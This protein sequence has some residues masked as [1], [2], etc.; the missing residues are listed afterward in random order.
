M[1]KLLMTL[2]A[3]ISSAGFLA[4]QARSQGPPQPQIDVLHYEIDAE[5]TPENGFLKGETKVRFMVPQDVLTIPF[6][7]N[8]RLSVTEIVD[9]EGTSYSTSFDGVESQRIAVRGEGPFRGGSEKTLIFRFE[10]ALE[11]QEYAFLDV[12]RSEKAV[13]FQD[14]ALLLTEGRW[15]PFY[16]L[17]LDAATADLKIKVPLGF[18]VVAPGVLQ[19]TEISGVTEIF[20]WKS[21]VPVTHV[22]VIVSRFFRHEVEQ[23]PVPT[24]LFVGEQQ[25]QDLK[26]LLTEINQVLEFLNKEYG[27]FPFEHLNIAAVGNVNLPSPGAAGLVLLEDSFLTTKVIPVVDLARRLAVQ[28]WGYSARPKEVY[29]AWLQDGFATYAALR[30]VETRYPD[31]YQTELARQAVNALKYEQKAAIGKGF[32]LEEGTPEYQSIIASKGAYVLYMLGQLMGKDK[33]NAMLVD[34]YKQHADNV[35]TT[36][37]FVRFVQ[38][39]SGQD[40]KWFFMQWVESTG[41]PDLRVDYQILKKKDGT[42]A[43]RGQVKQDQELFRM[44]LD[45]TIETK[46]QEEKKS[47]TLNGKSTSFN[48]PT[49]TLPIRMKLDPDGKIL[50]NSEQMQVL[51]QIALGEEYQAKGEYVEAVRAF[52]KA[53]EADPRSS[54]A[55]YRLGEVMFLQH[56]FTNAANA[57]RDTLNGDLKPE[58]VETWTHIYM[59]KIYDILNQRE[60]ATAEYQKA[61]NT[62]VD[63]NG[64]QAEAQKYLKEPFTKPQSIIG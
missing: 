7:L 16:R 45:I 61:I 43:V 47:L 4:A 21:A 37:E 32:E 38:E 11:R 33:L 20:T 59:G 1:K 5:I 6:E 41:I 39:R 57:F 23:A 2:L 18:S 48:F 58:W 49:Q 25:S 30:Y 52:E 19:P 24:T 14:G 56:S 53:R 50:R 29:D 13:I 44:P 64:A 55:A 22:P 9:P 31:R 42:F 36:P 40:Y 17:P 46:G 10:G 51:V 60:R 15:F 54:L 26:P 27:R 28:W 34:W 12:P 8:N 62:K 35:E 63:Y 3:L